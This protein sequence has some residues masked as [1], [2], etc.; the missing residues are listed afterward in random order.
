MPIPSFREKLKPLLDAPE[1]RKMKWNRLPG[2]Q[3]AAR[4]GRC[5]YLVFYQ[6][7]IVCPI[8]LYTHQEHESQPPYKEIISLVKEVMAYVSQ[9]YPLDAP[10]DSADC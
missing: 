5:I 3:G 4:Y 9:H 8:W 7:K 1:L 10:T 2:L 6:R